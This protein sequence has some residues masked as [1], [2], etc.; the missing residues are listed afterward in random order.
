M[1]SDLLPLKVEGDGK[2]PAG[3]FELGIA[4]GNET[5]VPNSTWAYKVM[6]KNDIFIDDSMSEF[7]NRFQ[8]K[9]S[10]KKDWNSFEE[11][12]RQDGLYNKAVVINHNMSP[13]K[14]G[15]GSAIFLHIWRSKTS[16][17]RGC[18][19]MSV[20]NIT[21]IIAWLKKESYPLLIQLP[22]NFAI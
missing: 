8:K 15:G 13:V 12:K 22:S 11:I 6:T 19:A 2:A 3:V 9:S 7:Y 20:D 16:A 5:K 18:T 21:S 17:T 10:I 4:F 14:P 1:H